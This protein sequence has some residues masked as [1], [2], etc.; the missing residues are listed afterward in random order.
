MP[1]PWP[2]GAANAGA[3]P[4]PNPDHTLLGRPAYPPLWRGEESEGR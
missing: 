2:A 1:G 4:D 3:E